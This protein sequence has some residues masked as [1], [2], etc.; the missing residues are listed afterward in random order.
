MQYLKSKSCS[1]QTGPVPFKL[2][3]ELFPH[4]VAQATIESRILLTFNQPQRFTSG[5]DAAD[6]EH[7][8]C[9]CAAPVNRA[10]VKHRIKPIKPDYAALKAESKM[11]G[12]LLPSNQ[13]LYAGRD[14]RARLM[15]R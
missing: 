14:K 1:K 13:R 7:L 2:G 8:Q 10:V 12:D 15:S 4:S 6:A 3:T 11:A 9:I 5:G